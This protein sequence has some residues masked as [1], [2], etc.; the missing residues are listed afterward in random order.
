MLINYSIYGSFEI[1]D[2]DI[3]ELKANLEKSKAAMKE[4]PTAFLQAD[5]ELHKKITEVTNNPILSRMADSLSKMGLASRGRTGEFFELLSQTLKDHNKIVKALE[6]R[7]PEAAQ[8]AMLEHLKHVGKKLEE[9]ISS[10]KSD[11]ELA[12]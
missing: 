6:A 5:V 1:E 11:E 12:K 9:L 2:E 8:R 10:E 7:D 4:D 3:V